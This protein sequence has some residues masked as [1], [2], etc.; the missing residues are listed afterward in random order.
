[1]KDPLTFAKFPGR[2]GVDASGQFYKPL[3]H[4]GHHLLS[5]SMG[6]LSEYVA[7]T[8]DYVRF[9]SMHD[10]FTTWHIL[11]PN[12]DAKWYGDCKIYF[13]REGGKI[14]RNVFL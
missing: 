5:Q 1:M 9:L 14:P 4:H 3:L 10:F 12:P 11:V 7:K 8:G 6:I 2:F 13:F